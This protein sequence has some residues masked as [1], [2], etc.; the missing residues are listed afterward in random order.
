[1]SGFMTVS[2]VGMG[3]P[4][5]MSKTC[6]VYRGGNLVQKGEKELC[7]PWTETGYSLKAWKGMETNT[8][9]EF[10]LTY[11]LMFDTEGIVEFKYRKDGVEHFGATNTETSGSFKFLVDGVVKIN[12]SD[13]PKD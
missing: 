13:D 9:V 8:L 12:D 1:M 11:A 7:E 2:E 6:K 10:D 3:M 5:R 4:L